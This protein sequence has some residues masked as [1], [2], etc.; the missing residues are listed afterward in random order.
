MD[1][2]RNKLLSHRGGEVYKRSLK[3]DDQLH[4]LDA[5][6]AELTHVRNNIED[7]SKSLHELATESLKTIEG[8]I[9]RI[10]SDESGQMIAIRADIE[11]FQ[12]EI[13]KG[14]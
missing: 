4:A 1:I 8:K 13:Q 5:M 11:T 12:H 14:R 3:L 9:E 7:L 10:R 6:N 2:I